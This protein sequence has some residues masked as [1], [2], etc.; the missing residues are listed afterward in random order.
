MEYSY[1]E[2]IHKIL[3]VKQGYLLEYMLIFVSLIDVPAQP[4]F[5]LI[6]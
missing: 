4:R 3:W 2:V 1:I 5:H 6:A